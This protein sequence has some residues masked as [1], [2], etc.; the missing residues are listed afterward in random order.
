MKLN[1]SGV[2]PVIFASSVLLFPLQIAQML[3]TR[4]GWLADVAYWL[5][6]GGVWYLVFYTLLIIFFAYFYTQV[7]LNPMEL[8]KNIR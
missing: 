2:I 7:T 8:A 5:R 3:G 4:V 6:P 1:P